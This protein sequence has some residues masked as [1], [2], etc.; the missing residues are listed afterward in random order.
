MERPSAYWEEGKR[1]KGTLG[2]KSTYA[3]YNNVGQKS[4]SEDWY[5]RMYT[6]EN[7]SSWV[8]WRC[9][10]G[11]GLK[12]NKYSLSKALHLIRL[13]INIR[14]AL[15]ESESEYLPFVYEMYFIVY[16]VFLHLS[17]HFVIQTILPWRQAFP[18]DAQRVGQTLL[19][20]HPISSLAL[21]LTQSQLIQAAIC[22]VKLQLR[23]GR[24]KEFWLWQRELKLLCR[25]H[26]KA[27]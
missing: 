6:H 24:W 20:T 12:F 9:L 13:S 22:P 3:H 4:E 25:A 10:K 17:F 11:N 27:L 14:F 26:G 1:G 15:W 23:M 8:I 18:L 16:E 5:L 19:V 7:A 2:R 21:F